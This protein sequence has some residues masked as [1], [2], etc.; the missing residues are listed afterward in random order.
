MYS[1]PGF[2]LFRRDRTLVAQPFDADS[3][4]ISGDSIPIAEQVDSSGRGALGLFSV[5]RNGVLVYITGRAV[6]Q[7]QLTWFDR[8]GK[9][10]EKVGPAGDL[11]WPV[12]SPDGKTVAVQR[13]EGES[14][15]QDIW[16]HDLARGS[17]YRL[18][19]HPNGSSTFPVWSPDS[20]YVGYSD[21]AWQTVPES[22]QRRGGRR[23]PVRV[24]AIHACR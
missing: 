1:T 16:L 6:G 13:T 14:G 23:G 5:S 2:L 24:E 12:I 18:T 3:A 9:A 15:I 20:L 4:R 22:G 19:S 7:A 10:L 11:A 21:P 17:S 8:S